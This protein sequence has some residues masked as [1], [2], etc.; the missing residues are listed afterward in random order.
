M[1]AARYVRTRSVEDRGRDGIRDRLR[2]DAAGRCPGPAARGRALRRPPAP[3][4][5]GCGSSR[6]GVLAGPADAGCGSARRGRRAGAHDAAA[7]ARAPRSSSAA[8]FRWMAVLLFIGSVGL[9]DR[10]HQLSPEQGLM[11]GVAAA[12]YGLAL[13]LRRPVAGGAILGAGIAVSFLSRGL[14]GPLWIVVTAL[15]LPA[16]FRSWRTGGYALAVGVA[17]AIAIPAGRRVAARALLSRTRA[18]ARVVGDAVVRRLFLPARGQCDGRSDVPVEESSVVRLAGSPAG[19][20]DAG[21]PRA[22]IQRRARHTGCSASG[23]ARA[24][25]GGFDVREDRAAGDRADA[26]C[27]CRCRCSA[28]SKSTR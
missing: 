17:L 24:G 9:W 10:A 7:R 28:R 3:R 11:L 15:A 12:L 5:R 14:L 16:A 6:H 21:D 22:R 8:S 23:D 2:N 25:H 19:A 26:V 13:G 27:W 4:L 1:G 18:L 20:L